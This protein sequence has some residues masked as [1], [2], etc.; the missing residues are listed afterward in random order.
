MQSNSADWH[1]ASIWQDEK[2]QQAWIRALEQNAAVGEDQQIKQ[3]R[4]SDRDLIK[5]KYG[6]AK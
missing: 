6:L 3:K 4:Q 1:T 2:E 5:Q